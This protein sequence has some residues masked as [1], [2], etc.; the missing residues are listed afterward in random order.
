MLT[1]VQNISAEWKH[2]HYRDGDL[3]ILT[4]LGGGDSRMFGDKE[5]RVIN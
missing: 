5:S 4:Q 2:C 3:A 1:T